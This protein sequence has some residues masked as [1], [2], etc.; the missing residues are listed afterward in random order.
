MKDRRGGSS[1]F[2]LTESN[3]KMGPWGARR[4]GPIDTLSLVQQAG[5]PPPIPAKHSC[6]RGAVRGADRQPVVKNSAPHSS[7]LSSSS[8]TTTAAIMINVIINS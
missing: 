8:I 7:R 2:F 4:Q 5:T 1:F 6:G 3:G